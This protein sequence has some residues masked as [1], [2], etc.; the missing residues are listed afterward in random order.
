MARVEQYLELCRQVW[1]YALRQPKDWISARKYQLNV[2]SITCEY[3]LI[4]E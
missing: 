2:Y 4:C 1:N 3:I